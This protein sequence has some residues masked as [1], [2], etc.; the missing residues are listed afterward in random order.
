MTT[1]SSD[2]TLKAAKEAVSQFPTN[3]EMMAW[4]WRRDGK[5]NR[6]TTNTVSWRDP[7]DICVWHTDGLCL[8]SH[9]LLSIHLQWHVFNRPSRTSSDAT[10]S[11]KPSSDS[12]HLFVQWEPMENY[13]ELLLTLPLY[14]YS[15][16]LFIYKEFLHQS[17]SSSRRIQPVSFVSFLFVVTVS[18]KHS[19]H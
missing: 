5:R 3:E 9:V 15:L 14:L 8:C 18:T 16:L 12:L 1:S 6:S 13:L 7:E 4:H 10:S 11:R 17:V 2:S 19:G